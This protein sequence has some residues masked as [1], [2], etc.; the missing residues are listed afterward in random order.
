MPKLKSH[1]GLAKRVKITGRGKVSHR[2]SGSSHLNSG[3]SG[4]ETRTLRKKM[5]CPKAVTRVL[6]RVMKTHLRGRDE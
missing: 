2:R 5:V 4:K 3:K 6:E 1:K